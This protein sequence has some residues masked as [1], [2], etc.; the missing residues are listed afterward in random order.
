MHRIVW[1][2]VLTVIA[3][4]ILEFSGVVAQDSDLNNEILP[5]PAAQTVI[6]GQANAA[7]NDVDNVN[8]VD[9]STRTIPSRPQ[10]P[11]R[12]QLFDNIFKVNY[13]SFEC[14]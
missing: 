5:V 2:I 7:N 10:R 9:S 8:Q 3:N 14:Y 1:L 12:N 6:N 13:E 11:S 4:I